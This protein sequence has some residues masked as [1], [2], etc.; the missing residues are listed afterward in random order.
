MTQTLTAVASIS[1]GA[2]IVLL[3]GAPIVFAPVGGIVAY[4]TARGVAH[5]LRADRKRRT[6]LDVLAHD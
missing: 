1:A 6:L 4:G 5:L 3:V 2:L